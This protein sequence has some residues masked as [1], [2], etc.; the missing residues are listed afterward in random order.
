M[1]PLMEYFCGWSDDLCGPEKEKD[2]HVMPPMSPKEEEC[3]EN[4]KT[5]FP[6]ASAE[7]INTAVIAAKGH[8]GKAAAILRENHVDPRT[9]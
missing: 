1:M 3:A 7:E 6:T 9:I 2:T 8:G 4:L 5:R